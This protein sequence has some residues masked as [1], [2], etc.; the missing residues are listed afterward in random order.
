MK[1]RKSKKGIVTTK[2]R[3]KLQ[4]MAAKLKRQAWNL[5]GGVGLVTVILLLIQWMNGGGW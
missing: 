3:S 1:R 5:L 4:V 2:R